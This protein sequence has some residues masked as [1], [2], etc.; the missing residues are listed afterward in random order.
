MT[1][2]TA[3]LIREAAHRLF[4]QH[5]T[6]DVLHRAESGEWP[7]ALWDAVEEAGFLDTLADREIAR[8]NRIGIDVPNHRAI[9]G[10]EM[11]IEKVVQPQL[12]LVEPQD[13][14]GYAACFQK[15]RGPPKRV[16]GHRA[17]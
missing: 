12:H 4:A 6:N 14:E 16:A 7:E 15:S 8:R 9:G 3:N 10:L 5:V 11:V 17:G 1:S 13:V 2:E